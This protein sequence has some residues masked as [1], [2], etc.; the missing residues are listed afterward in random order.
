L[1]AY[2][3]AKRHPEVIDL[4]KDLRDKAPEVLSKMWGPARKAGTVHP[5]SAGSSNEFHSS[6]Q[7][8]WPKP[9]HSG[10]PSSSTSNHSGSVR[11]D[12]SNPKG[13][14]SNATPTS[15]ANGVRPST[16]EKGIKVTN[17]NGIYSTAAPPSGDRG[18]SVIRNP[19]GTYRG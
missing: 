17:K 8:G 7:A 18:V 16:L 1:A 2:K 10:G 11:R 14:P 19:D 6:P 4:A 5:A 3:F 13:R 15:P 9:S 12:K